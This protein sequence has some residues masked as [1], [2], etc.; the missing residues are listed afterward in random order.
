MLQDTTKQMTSLICYAE[1]NY[2]LLFISTLFHSHEWNRQN[3]THQEK[4]QNSAYLS[5]GEM[6]G[7]GDEETF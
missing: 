5:G 4:Y 2:M 1:L 7:K 3:L 6:T